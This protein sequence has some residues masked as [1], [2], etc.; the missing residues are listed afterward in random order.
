MRQVLA[1][2]PIERRQ[3]VRLRVDH[4]DPALPW[5]VAPRQPHE[6]HPRKRGLA[7]ARQTTQQNV[8]CSVSEAQD[9]QIAHVADPQAGLRPA[10]AVG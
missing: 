10:A 3:V 1:Q 8:G 7:T 5:R 9:G 6:D 4:D 2:R